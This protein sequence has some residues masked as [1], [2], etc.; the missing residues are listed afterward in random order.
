MQGTIW[1]WQQFHGPIISLSAS[2]VNQ[3]F[4]DHEWMEIDLITLALSFSHAD[5]A[6]RS[7]FVFCN[8]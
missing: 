6:C 1:L 5:A 3:V 2:Q 4:N 8:P 7:G